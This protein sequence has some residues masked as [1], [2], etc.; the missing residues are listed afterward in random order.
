MMTSCIRF[1]FGLSLGLALWASHGHATVVEPLSIGQLAAESN[2]VV[3]AVVDHVYTVPE[4]GPRGEIYTRTELV[5]DEYIIGDGPDAITVQ[6]LGGR[7][8]EWTML[9]SGNADFAPG[10]EVIVFLDYEPAKDVHYVVGLAQGM[11][12][13]DRTGD[14]TSLS[15]NLAGL[16]FYLAEPMP[17]Q[18]GHVEHTLESLLNA[19]SPTPPVLDGSTLRA[20][21]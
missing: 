12:T 11:F 13:I 20:V 9:L 8:G 5:I 15:R 3:R 1:V 2:R 7:L 4:R 14:Y 10:A 16:S 19:L 21:Q 17:F 18:P 6:Q